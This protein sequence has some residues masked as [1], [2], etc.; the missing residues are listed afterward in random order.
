MKWKFLEHG[1]CYRS[2][3]NILGGTRAR[4]LAVEKLLPMSADGAATSV[5]D[6]GCGVGDVLHW[7]PKSWSYAALDIS[8]QYIGLAS[9]TWGQRGE[10]H[11]ASACKAHEV[12]PLASQNIVLLLGV[13][14]HMDSE[15]V[16]A[17]LES[18]RRCLKPN[19]IVYALE[20]A[21]WPGQSKV[22]R[23]VM[24]LDRGEFIRDIT[25][26]REVCHRVFSNVEI[27]EL[28]RALRIPYHK[29]TLTL[30]K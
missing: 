10:F 17:S 2:V 23:W 26:W 12:V 9:A 5:L 27:A 8:P 22:S 13:L 19:G 1:F 11:V 7:I 30:S 3:Q 21:Y 20:P 4:R 25:G 6:V 14:H 15:T 18:A 29:V 24:S 16:I 28:P